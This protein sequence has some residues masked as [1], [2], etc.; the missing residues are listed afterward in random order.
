M[1]EVRVAGCAC[2]RSRATRLA[3][4]MESAAL[5][6][7]AMWSPGRDGLDHRPHAYIS[8]IAAGPN[9]V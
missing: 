5:L 4:S 2:L 3:W 6:C 9:L 7:F 1:V 8:G